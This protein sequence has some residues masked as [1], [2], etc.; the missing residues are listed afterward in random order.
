MILS[1]LAG[2]I[3]FHLKNEKVKDGLA[4]SM[5]SLGYGAI[6]SIINFIFIISVLPNL[7]DSISPGDLSLFASLFGF[8]ILLGLLVTK[9]LFEYVTKIQFLLDYFKKINQWFSNKLKNWAKL[10]GAIFK[11]YSPWISIIL[12]VFIFFIILINWPNPNNVLLFLPYIFYGIILIII[13]LKLDSGYGKKWA[14]LFLLVWFAA[15]L[16]LLPGY[17]GELNK[18]F[19]HFK[20]INHSDEKLDF[21]VINKKEDT[22][23]VTKIFVECAQDI[24]KV[25]TIECG[26]PVEILSHQA[27]RIICDENQTPR[28]CNYTPFINDININ[29]YIP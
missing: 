5:Y 28:D 22:V 15:T 2:S 29:K 26:L 4:R 21:S 24:R 3:F 1:F 18:S 25:L 10:N 20:I 16:F 6:W 8:I 14:L 27:K 17:A 7:W 12:G 23:I 13:Y 11:K 9:I 19:S